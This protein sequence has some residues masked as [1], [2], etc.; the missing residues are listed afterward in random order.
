MLHEYRGKARWRKRCKTYCRPYASNDLL[1][2]PRIMNRPISRVD[3]SRSS[4]IMVVLQI[5]QKVGNFPCPPPLFTTSCC[6]SIFEM[7]RLLIGQTRHRTR[8]FRIDAM[9]RC[10]IVHACLSWPFPFSTLN[11]P[12][13]LRLLFP[14]SVTSNL[15]LYNI[16]PITPGAQLATL[17]YQ[18]VPIKL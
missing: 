14:A 16:P 13:P 2:C 12:R 17:Q 18:T 7:P 10:G 15:P 11:L 1:T 9:C 6:P 8:L 3:R 4:S 5:P